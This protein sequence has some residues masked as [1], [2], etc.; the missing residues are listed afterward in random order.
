MTPRTNTRTSRTTDLPARRVEDDAQDQTHDE[1][2]PQGNAE[3]RHGILGLL[4]RRLV[5]TRHITQK[6]ADRD[7]R[8]GGQ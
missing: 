5:V 6:L 3:R 1:H 7:V 2:R 4:L 8:A